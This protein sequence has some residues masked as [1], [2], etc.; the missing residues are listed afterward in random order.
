MTLTQVW[1]AILIFTVCPLLGGLPLTAWLTYPLSRRKLR[2]N[3]AKN[4]AVSEPGNSEGSLTVVLTVLLEAIEGI[5]AVLLARQFF[6]TDPEWE[7]IALISLVMGRYWIAKK[8]GITSAVWGF[9]VHDWIAAGFVF[10]IGGISLTILRERRLGQI[11]FLILMPLTI[12][13]LHL[14]DGARITAAVGLSA[15]LYWIYQKIPEQQR[16]GERGKTTAREVFLFFRSDRAIISLDRPR[17]P[18]RVGRKAAILSTLKRA[19]YPVLP[20]WVLPSGDDPQA[21]IDFLKPSQ[22]SPLAV[23][24]SNLAEDAEI[25]SAAG[26]YASIFN[27]TSPEALHQAI[28]YC[29][30]S[31]F[32][33]VGEQYR[34][35]RQLPEASMAVLIQP[36]IRGVFSGVA[37]SRDPIERSGEAVVIEALPGDIAPIVSGT[38]TPELYRVYLNINDVDPVPSGVVPKTAGLEIDGSGNIPPE[39]LEEVAL[40]ARQLENRYQGIPQDIQWTYDGEKLWLLQVRAIATMLPIW[41]RQIAAEVIPGIVRPLSWAIARPLTCNVWENLFTLLLGKK[42]ARHLDFRAAAALQYSRAYCN[43]SELGQKFQRLGLPQKSWEFFLTPVALIRSAFPKPA[44]AALRNLPGFLRL[45]HR[46]LS[47]AIDFDRACRFRFARALAELAEE[48]NLE[49]DPESNRLLGLRPKA[50][51]KRIDFILEQLEDCS[52]YYILSPLSLALRKNML[53]VRDEE[54]DYSQMP[55]VAAERS[56]L[57]LAAATRLLLPD[58]NELLSGD[59]S[60]D[61]SELFATLAEIPDCQSLFEEFEQLLDRYG[62]LSEVPNDIALPTWK[63]DPRHLRELFAEMLFDPSSAPPSP[64][65][66]H[67]LKAQIVQNRVSLQ[68]RVCETY[69]KLLAELRWSFVALENIWLNLGALSGAGDIF[70]LELEEIRQLVAVDSDRVSQLPLDDLHQLIAERRAKLELDSKVTSVPPIIYGEAVNIYPQSQ[71]SLSRSP[72]QGIGASPGIAV[73]RVKI[74]ANWSYA[75]EIS[76]ET[77]VVVPYTDAR[78]IPALAEAAGVIS[79]VGGQLSHGAI[80]AREYGIPAVMNIPEASRWLRDGQRVRIDGRQGTVE[81]LE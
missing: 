34:R 51:L 66:L 73:G 47:L 13:L 4:I 46:E 17:S 80:V 52:Y 19:G 7:L 21:L 25:A 14:E 28:N 40:L 70:F 9:A 60:Q 33:P 78:W 72:I 61:Y 38:A 30:E 36:Y 29:L 71:L 45:L 32:R 68:S 11:G 67:S 53:G 75:R 27:V 3:A 62:Y 42:R 59:R 12:A 24:S 26:Q 16:S 55:E 56:L 20:G 58:P 41:T 48:S 35:D 39:L 2:E 22:S 10:F 77:I 31:C 23:H 54:L 74:I 8:A 6:P 50:V 49:S 15:L 5:A 81:V 18:S 69:R 37:F 63:E 79:E 57:E 76:R 44:L 1:G 65:K 43:V 64:P